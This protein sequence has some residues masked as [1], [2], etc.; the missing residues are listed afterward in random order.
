MPAI[1]GHHHWFLFFLGQRLVIFDANANGA[2]KVRT[3]FVLR[4]HSAFAAFGHEAAFD[5]DGRN[6]RQPQDGEARALDSAIRFRGVPEDRMINTRGDSNAV[7]VDASAGLHIHKTEGERIVIGGRRAARGE[8]INFKSA[9]IRIAIGGVEMQADEDRVLRGGGDTGTQLQ[10]HKVI[11]FARQNYFQSLGLKHRPKFSRDIERVIFFV[12]E[13]ADR[14]FVMPAMPRI[15]HDCGQFADA[16][17]HVRTHLRLNRFRQVHARDEKFAV[18]LNDRET[19]PVARAVDEDLAAVEREL[20]RTFRI[21]GLDLF[22]RRDW[23]RQRVKLRD[24]IDAQIIVRADFDDLPWDGRG[25]CVRAH[26]HRDRR[27]NARQFR[28]SPHQNVL[29]KKAVMPRAQGLS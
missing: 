27:E 7:R 12:T 14:A 15:E 11:A 21:L 2:R 26:R 20:E 16:R 18:L 4:D 24:V 25:S 13:L 17:D 8:T 23:S 19:E 6:L 28:K 29:E 5:Q 1:I 22:V 9:R 3:P 10:G